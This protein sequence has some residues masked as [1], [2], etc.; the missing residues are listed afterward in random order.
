MFN[1]LKDNRKDRKEVALVLSTG[2]ARG[3]AHIGAID[4]LREMG[5]H[6]HSVAG[7]SMGALVG[8]MYAAGRLDDFKQWMS[9]VDRRKI[10][11]LLDF[12]LS[13]SHLMKGDRVID[14]MMR[15]VPDVNIEDLA[16]PY[17]AVA[18]D[19]V[20]GTEVVF[21]KGSLYEAIRASIS[22]PLFFNPVRSGERVLIDGGLVN[23]LPLNRVR[24]KGDDLLVAVNVSGHD[25]RG[26]AELRKMVREQNER[27][28]IM[29]LINKMLP[30]DMNMNYYS[31]LNRSISIMINKNAQQAVRLTPPDILVD[32]PMNRYNTFDFDKYERLASIGRNKTRKAVE[33][34][35]E[36]AGQP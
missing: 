2:G 36:N 29:S 10:F 8:G 4:Q 7:T 28:R 18:T 26:Q 16:I 15:V 14:E 17:C 33:H 11:S 27:S 20:S 35:L 23:P 1:W 3:L 6:V 13:I 21:R 32:I 31:L 30:N 24:R 9:T 25:Y 22:L 19:V 12:S 34:F 5:Y